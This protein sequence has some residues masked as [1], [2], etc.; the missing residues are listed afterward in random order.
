MHEITK[1]KKNNSA[2]KTST[3]SDTTGPAMVAK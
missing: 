3:F 2:L 1:E